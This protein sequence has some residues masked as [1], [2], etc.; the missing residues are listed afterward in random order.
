MILTVLI[1]IP[2]HG[3]QKRVL[4]LLG[5]VPRLF[6]LEQ[7]KHRD[8]VSNLNFDSLSYELGKISWPKVDEVTFEEGD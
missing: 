7:L 1:N 5:K 2:V 4:S 8:E 3:S 6:N